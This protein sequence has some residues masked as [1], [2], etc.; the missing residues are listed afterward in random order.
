[1]EA[2]IVGSIL[3]GIIASVCFAVLMLL[4]RPIIKVS[5]KMTVQRGAVSVYKVKVV[6]KTFAM[7]TN[8]K[9]SLH[10]CVDYD[11]GTT[12]IT[13]IK[14]MKEKLSVIDRY[15]PFDKQGIYAV[16]ISYEVDEN[17]FP[18]KDNTRMVF[19]ILADHAISN[20]TACK[21]VDYKAENIVEAIFETGKSTKAIYTEHK[22]FSK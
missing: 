19:T 9:Y 5:N 15:S 18:M 16:R 3:S 4:I 22:N 14:P 7:L 8:V 10:Y 1:M 20:T 11:D 2:Q 13:E 17:K 12:D 21:K 6:N